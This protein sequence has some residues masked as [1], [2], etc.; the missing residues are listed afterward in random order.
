M[1]LSIIFTHLSQKPSRGED[2]GRGGA[3][4]HAV[5]AQS[6]GYGVR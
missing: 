2:D 6:F 1:K 5:S 3:P 4:H